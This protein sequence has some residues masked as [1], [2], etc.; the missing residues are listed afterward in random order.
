M[1]LRAFLGVAAAAALLSAAPASATPEDPYGEDWVAIAVAP[2]AHIGTYGAAGSAEAATQIAMDECRQRS[3][4]ARCQIATA[5]QY[6]CVAFGIDVR[7]NTWAGGRG[8]NEDAALSDVIT[9][10]PPDFAEGD[11]V[12]GPACSTPRTRP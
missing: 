9:K 11:V 1:N 3:N 8:P 2:E 12:G 4:G 7:T 5:T 6:G 10:L